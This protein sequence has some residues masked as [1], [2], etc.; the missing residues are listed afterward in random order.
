[1]KNF[2][3][4][5]VWHKSHS[6]ALCIYRE[7]E[8]FPPSELYGL[9]AQIRRAATSIPTNISEGCGRASETEFR[10]FLEIAFASANEVEYQILLTRDL[11]YLTEESYTALNDQVTEV[12]RMISALIKKLRMDSRR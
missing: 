4:L 3:D 5:K 8:N 10:R 12:K 7:T 1:M 6:L 11:E 9:R 2:R